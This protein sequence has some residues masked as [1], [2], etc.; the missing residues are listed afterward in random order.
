MQKRTLGNSNL[1]VS[2]LGIGCMRMSFGDTPTDKQEMLSFLHAAVD[3]A[4]HFFDTAEVY[5][6]VY[7]RRTRW[8]ALEPFKGH[9]SSPPSSG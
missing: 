6:P 9:V 3:R 4:L 8:R 1:E 7:K 2:A 5:G